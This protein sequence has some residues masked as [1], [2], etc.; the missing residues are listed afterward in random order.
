MIMGSRARTLRN[1]RLVY[2]LATFLSVLFLLPVLWA[3]LSSL[4]SSSQFIEY[5]PRFF[6]SPFE[7]SNY[8]KVWELTPLAIYFRNSL[9]IAIPVL[10]GRLTMSSLIGYGFARFRFRGKNVLFLLMLS[11]M[12]LPQVVTMVPQ[13]LIFKNLGLLNTILPLVIPAFLGVGLGGPFSIFVFR[14]FFMTLPLDL[15]EAAR[16]DGAGPL[17][18][19]RMIIVPLSRP[20][21][22][23]LAIF[24]F[25]ITWND[26][27]GPLIYLRTEQT[28]TI[29]L[30]LAN[31]L[32]YSSL[33]PSE[34]ILNLLMV[35]AIITALPVVI[36]FIIGQKYYVK[37]MT[38]GGM[39]G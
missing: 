5:P 27:L 38:M 28:Y 16:I 39:K 33:T 1:K 6:P 14:Q 26:Y 36:I 31:F 3:V 25:F 24:N 2:L 12:M 22:A 4:K 17:R 32:Y 15:D 23:A 8:I 19:F 35:A 13:F 37:G 30:G 29:P 20:V 7:W 18:I 34:P 9:L 11:T 10:I 21:F